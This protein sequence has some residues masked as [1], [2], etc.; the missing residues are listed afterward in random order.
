[1]VAGVRT[2]IADGVPEGAGGV[3][4][5]QDRAGWVPVLTGAEA[6]TALAV[7]EGIA[8]DL[9]AFELVHPTALDD[10]ASLASGRAGIALFHLYRYRATGNPE[11]RA[12]ALRVLNAAIDDAAAVSG[13][14]SLFAGLAGVGFAVSHTA[15]WL[16]AD[17]DGLLGRLDA[18]LLGLVEA[19]G[20][21]GPLDLVDGLVG[22]GV[23]GLERLPSPAGARLVAEVAA[24]LEERAERRDDGLTW[25]TPPRL[26]PD[27]WPR[28]TPAGRYDLGMAH[29]VPGVVAFLARVGQ[30]GLVVSGRPLLEGAVSWL[31]S[32]ALNRAEWDNA[33]FPAW[34][35]AD[36][37]PQGPARTAWC[38]GDPGAAAALAAAAQEAG[39][40]EW[41]EVARTLARRA[42]RR[43]VDETGVCD[44][45]LCHGAGGLG[46]VFVRLHQALGDPDLRR[47]ARRW[48][49]HTLGLARPGTGFGGYSTWRYRHEATGRFEEDPGLLE[50][51]AGV[52]LALLAAA[53]AVEPAWDRVLLLS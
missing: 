25:S 13:G 11:A 2:R 29:G 49:R 36:A 30:A 51:G 41:W 24:R 17:A 53:T 28:L 43:P 12:E 9:A 18:A 14:T 3:S 38:Y 35:A 37:E 20:W 8:D 32:Q 52:G 42:A 5:E 27:P 44:G 7:V 23:Y 26:L 45:C 46:L 40:P 22:V 19:P 39:R 6:R 21:D 47:A 31:Q 15:R 34:T 16:G 4:G 1:M 48:F 50:G 33:S 10:A